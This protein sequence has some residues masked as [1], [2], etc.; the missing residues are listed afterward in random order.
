MGSSYIYTTVY[1]D[2]HRV[3]QVIFAG[4]IPVIM[5][6]VL[7]LALTVLKTLGPALKASRLRKGYSIATFLLENGE[8]AI[9]I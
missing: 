9:T 6:D 7:V 8:H 3:V 5:A 2:A 4:R 1:G